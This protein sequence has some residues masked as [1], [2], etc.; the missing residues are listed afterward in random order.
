MHYHHYEAN[1]DI[2]ADDDVTHLGAG[3]LPPPDPLLPGPINSPRRPARQIHPS[4][5]PPC[6]KHNN[7]LQKKH[8]L[9]RK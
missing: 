5:Q 7:D 6:H 4:P 9:V 1:N 2:L 3:D 8:F